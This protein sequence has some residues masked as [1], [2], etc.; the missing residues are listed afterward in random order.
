MRRVLSAHKEPH[1][2]IGLIRWW[3]REYGSLTSAEFDALMDVLADS[4]DNGGAG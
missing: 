4:C 1:L 3:L 2:A